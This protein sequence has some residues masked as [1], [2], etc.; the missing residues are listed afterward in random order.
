MV[1]EYLA[2]LPPRPPS[3]PISDEEFDK[4]DGILASIDVD[5]ESNIEEVPPYNEQMLQLMFKQENDI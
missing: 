4:T 1:E 2:T 3:I 5:I